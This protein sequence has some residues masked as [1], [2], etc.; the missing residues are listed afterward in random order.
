MLSYDVSD[1]EFGKYTIIHTEDGEFMIFYGGNLDIYLIPSHKNYEEL[2]IEYTITKENYYL[3]NAFNTLYERI[4]NYDFSSIYDEASREKYKMVDQ[5]RDYPL[6][7]DNTVNWYSDDDVIDEASMLE[8]SKEDEDSIKLVFN[9]SKSW[10]LGR[11]TYSIRIRNCG[12]RYRPANYVFMEL[13]NNLT[14]QN[15]DYYPQIH[16]EEYI[17]S[18]KRVLKK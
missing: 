18:Q 11:N 7:K 15:K 10:E 14:Y 17:Y 4:I 5:G 12:S 16:M 2:Q 13:Y 1:S 9:K 3:F 8:I 6:V